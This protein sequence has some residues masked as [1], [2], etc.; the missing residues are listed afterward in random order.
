MP[1][2]D[3]ISLQL[4]SDEALVLFDLLGRWLED[5]RGNTLR[6]ILSDRAEFWALNGLYC[7][8]EAT[9]AEPFRED[10]RALVHNAQARLRSR[11]GP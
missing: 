4:D 8:L 11:N 6:P 3:Q 2:P 1:E 7:L 5:E 9:L 10:Y